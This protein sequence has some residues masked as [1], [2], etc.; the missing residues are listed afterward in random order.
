MYTSHGHRISGLGSSKNHAQ[1]WH[2]HHCSG[3]SVVTRRSHS[4]TSYPCITVCRSQ[5]ARWV[6]LSRRHA[7]MLK[8]SSNSLHGVQGF[9]ELVLTC[10]ASGRAGNSVAPHSVR[11]RQR[12]SMPGYMNAM[13]C[14]EIPYFPV[15]AATDLAAMRSSVSSPRHP[16]CR[17]DVWLAQRKEGISS[18]LPLL[19]SYGSSSPRCGSL[20]DRSL[21]GHE[22]PETT[23][24][25]LHADMR[26]KERAL[27]RTDP[28]GVKPARYHPDDK[29]L[30]F[31]L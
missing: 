4:L 10:A 16:S 7:I 18:C 5:S 27:S 26:L 20:R 1:V 2:E 22:S 21:A 8:I 29:L 6:K 24:M 14:L 13:V 9:S 30:A 15:S 31:L 3:P 28:L 12:R 19:R 11:K 23:Q 25:Y 17:T